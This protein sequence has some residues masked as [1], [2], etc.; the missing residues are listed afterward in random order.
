MKKIGEKFQL[1]IQAIV[2][3]SEEKNLGADKITAIK[4]ACEKCN[5]EVDD[6]TNR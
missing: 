6:K 1:D 3:K 5:A 4:T 2:K